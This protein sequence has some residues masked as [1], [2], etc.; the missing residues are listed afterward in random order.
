M[1]KSHWQDWV[2]VL[3]GLWIF[4]SPWLLE[5]TMVT[6]V[7]GGG[8][9]GMWNAWVVGLAVVLIAGIATSAYSAWAEWTNV[10]LGAWLLVSPWA[11][12]FSQSAVLMWNAVIFGALVL[13][14]A[15]WALAEKPKQPS[16]GL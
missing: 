16:T 1:N 14:F 6:E 7:S 3:L 8:L 12:G 11:L 2:N 5:H 9:L 10:A 15:G 13:G 4:G